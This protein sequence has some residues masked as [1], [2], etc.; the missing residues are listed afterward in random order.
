MLMH[1]LEYLMDKNGQTKA[2]VVPIELWNRLFLRND[3]SDEDLS[4]AMED[5]CLNKAMDEAKETPLLNRDEA[6]AWLES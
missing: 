1:E 5:Y 4:E 3:T 6:L 2:V